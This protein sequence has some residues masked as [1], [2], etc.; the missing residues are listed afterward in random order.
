MSSRRR[1][2]SFKRILKHKI[3]RTRNVFSL[4]CIIFSIIF[5]GSLLLLSIIP[6]YYFILIVF[7]SLVLNTVAIVF[8]NV[9]RKKVL[10]V[11]G[12]VLIGVL[13]LVNLLGLYYVV[14]TDNYLNEKFGYKNSY[15]KQAFYILSRK[16]SN[17]VESDIH[18]NIGIFQES[19]HSEEAFSKI[20]DKFSVKGKPYSNLSIMFQDLINGVVDFL[21]MDQASYDVFFSLSNNYHKNDYTILHE[22]DLFSKKEK[23]NTT[24]KDSFQVFV[25]LK[26][27][28]GI[29]EYAMILSVNRIEKKVL[30]T[31]IPNNYYFSVS[32][33]DSIQDSLMYMNLYDQDSLIDSLEGLFNISIDYSIILNLEQ[34]SK[35]IDYLGGISY[36]SDYE[37][38]TTYSFYRN[39]SKE[40]DKVVVNKGCQMI[41]GKDALAISRE[42]LAFPEG[43]KTRGENG[44]QIIES[45]LNRYIQFK[46]LTHFNEVLNL[47]KDLF[48][49]DIPRELFIDLTRDLVFHKNSWISSQQTLTGMP[50]IN[51]VYHSN[52][53]D[54]VL[55]AN[56]SSILM[57]TENIKKVCNS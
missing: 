18:G 15:L 40:G 5:L 36:C 57:I 55:I 23:S 8:I 6:F 47:S 4:F 46:V 22:F 28:T 30:V 31:N 38:T 37:Y 54:Q 52:L 14:N 32:G 53:N 45:T 2:K 41:H 51:L 39:L 9:H 42:V 43:E 7:I 10:K 50:S 13:I 26:N 56:E 35:V 24:K 27:T 34:F 19:Y 1:K 49:T 12:S 3:F 25:G 11:I 17:Y 48:E 20:S 16:E 29:M 33:R 44:K 21:L